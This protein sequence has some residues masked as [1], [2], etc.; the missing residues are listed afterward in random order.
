MNP[1]TPIQWYY[2]KEGAQYGPL[3]QATL[4]NL[5][6]A[7]GIAP[8]D[9]LWNTTL[10]DQWVEAASMPEIFAAPQETPPEALP[11]LPILDGTTPNR[12]LMA[13]ARASLKGRWGMGVLAVLIYIFIL[14]TPTIIRMATNP[15][16]L[17]LPHLQAGKIVPA[18]PPKYTVQPTGPR[19]IKSALSFAVSF[20][21]ILVACPLVVGLMRFFLNL[22]RKEA[23]GLGD[24]FIGFRSGA[25]YYW[26]TVGVN[27]L[28]GV[29]VI[30]WALLYFIPAI[31]FG[32]WAGTTHHLVNHGFLSILWVLGSI[33]FILLIIR[34][35][36]YKMTF[37]IIAD[38][39]SVRAMEAIRRSTRMMKAKKWKFFCLGWRFFGWT[40]L[41]LL[42]C[43]I[44][45]L[46][47]DV[48]GMTSSANFYDDVKDRAA[49]A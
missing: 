40:L 42:T 35:Y 25:S 41:C 43:G 48:Y 46:W 31:A 6:R 27:L 5:A 24:L 12:E 45:F 9:L 8:T 36:S 33:T 19:L 14:E 38:D 7:G 44:G 3:D 1:E 2:T 15:G 4:R 11:V 47:V 37:F 20:A 21:S 16:L 34:V 28:L 23:A 49:I 26:R 22:A 18:T 29:I 39:Q 30:G 13:R 10:G 32:I 17:A